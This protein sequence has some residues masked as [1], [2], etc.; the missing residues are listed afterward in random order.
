VSSSLDDI[1]ARFTALHPRIID[2]SLGRIER[3]MET[4]GHPEKKL[5]PVVHVAGTNGKGSVVAFMRAALEAAGYRCHIYTSPHLVKFNE[6]IVLAGREI[7]DAPLTALLERVEATNAGAEITFFEITTAAAFLAFAETPADILLLEVGLG[8]RLDATNVVAKPAVT[9]ITPVDLDHQKYLGDTLAAIAGEKAGI[10]KPRVPAIVSAQRPEAMAPIAMRAEAIGTPLLLEQRD[11]RA[12]P[13]RDGFR[14]EGP[15]WT[16]DMPKPNL[17]GAHQFHNAGAAL[18][19]L[20]Q[21][22]ALK[23]DTPALTEGVTKACWPAR[24]QRLTRGPLTKKLPPGWELW[25]DGAHNPHGARALAAWLAAQ[26]KPA[27]LVTAMLDSK[28]PIGFF[29]ELKGHIGLLRTV[30]VP[31][32]H[33]GLDPVRLAETAVRA[34]H[35]ASSV[36]DP[37]AAIAEIVAHAGKAPAIVM[38]AGSLY[39]AGAILAENA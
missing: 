8:G 32:G 22:T 29:E 25:L 3:L 16:L 28:D 26:K 34:G 35:K 38:I 18:A 37:A 24:L 7:A 5:P 19:C 31:G 12:V 10:L 27:H 21:L 39:L 17:L 33:S 13:G 2:L 36:A 6:R 30:P 15:R 14:Y 23:L 20:E 1:L 9:C 4:L 11:W